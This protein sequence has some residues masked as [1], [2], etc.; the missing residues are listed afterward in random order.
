M[1][2]PIDDLIGKWNWETEIFVWSR[3][4]YTDIFDPGLIHYHEQCA[5]VDVIHDPSEVPPQGHPS[6]LNFLVY[7]PQNSIG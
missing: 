4:E 1:T 6:Y 5:R 3:I 7:G 2:I